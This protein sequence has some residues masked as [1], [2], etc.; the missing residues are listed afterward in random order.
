[1][2]A[3]LGYGKA[4]VAGLASLVL[5][6]AGVAYFLVG[7]TYAV[8]GEQCSAAGVCRSYS[9]THPGSWST[10]LLVPLLSALLVAGAAFLGRWKV[11]S[12]VLAASGCLG[13]AVITVL[14]ALSI[15]SLFLPADI[16]AAGAVLLMRSPAK[17]ADGSH[18]HNPRSAR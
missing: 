9:A 8:S 2:H 6:A 1:M 15:G 3:R 12:R 10:I 11:V 4:T 14:G 13:L 7:P 17:K 16:A 5:A 18:P